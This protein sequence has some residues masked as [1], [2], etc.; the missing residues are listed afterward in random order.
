MVVR[1]VTPDL[2]GNWIIEIFET[3]AADSQCMR[4]FCTT[5]GA[6]DFRTAVTRAAVDAAGIELPRQFQERNFY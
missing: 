5:C 1:E 3:S 4:P 2:F 6:L